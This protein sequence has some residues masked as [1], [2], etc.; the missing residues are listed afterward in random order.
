MVKNKIKNKKSFTVKWFDSV[1]KSL[2]QYRNVLCNYFDIKAWLSLFVTLYLAALALQIIPCETF[3]FP[4]WQ[5][6]G[7]C[8]KG[9]HMGSS[10]FIPGTVQQKASE[11][12]A[13]GAVAVLDC[14]MKVS[15]FTYH[16]ALFSCSVIK[17]HP[18]PCGEQGNERCLMKCRV[19]PLFP[20]C[21]ILRE[22]LTGVSSRCRTQGLSSQPHMPRVWYQKN[23]RD[24]GS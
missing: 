22:W 9:K 12:T 6:R 4:L 7:S 14:R 15:S 19:C 1:L 23:Q 18:N 17:F 8:S 10:K 3:H 5:T 11:V 21:I 20:S 2:G 16:E 24:L 13:F